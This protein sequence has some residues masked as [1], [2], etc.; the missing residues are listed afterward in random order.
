MLAS[1]DGSPPAVRPSIP[2][3]T[4]ALPHPI[5]KR[6]SGR[7]N[8]EFKLFLSVRARKNRELILVE[9]PK[10]LGEAVRSKMNLDVVAF[11][12]RVVS[13]SEGVL[14]DCTPRLWVQFAA[15]LMKSL[16]DV[17]THQGVLALVERPRFEPD[18]LTKPDPFLL[19]LDG[20]QDPGNVGTLLRTAEAAGVSGVLLTRGCA[21]PFSPKALRASAGSAFRV[22]HILDLSPRDALSLMPRGLRLAAAVAGADAA[23]VFGEA[24]L[25][26]PLAL[27]LGSEGQGLSPEIETAASLRV[28]VPAAARVESLNVAAA[29]AV[30]MFEIARRSG[31]LG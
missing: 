21:D 17:L 26:T 11:D 24:P 19:L 3:K 18:W 30:L 29:G 5:P 2:L 12:D 9:G 7:D 4:Q 27:A 25:V 1:P 28:R 16:A 10:L 6:I 14:K 8:P 31:R 15:P 22:P 20:L 13:V 23:S